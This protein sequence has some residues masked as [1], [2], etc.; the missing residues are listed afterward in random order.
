MRH[1]L[2]MC[3]AHNH[4]PRRFLKRGRGSCTNSTHFNVSDLHVAVSDVLHNASPTSLRFDAHATLCSIQLHSHTTHT[5]VCTCVCH[6][7]FGKHVFCQP[8]R[9][10]LKISLSLSPDLQNL[11]LFSHAPTQ[12]PSSYREV[13]ERDVDNIPRHF[14]ANRDAVSEPKRH[15][16]NLLRAKDPPPNEKAATSTSNEHQQQA[17]ATST[18]NEQRIPWR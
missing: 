7:W 11:P 1:V 8:V 14:T 15:V 3:C 4:E 9:E 16:A 10:C 17:P 18:S 5:H 12:H 2:C 6:K 13:E